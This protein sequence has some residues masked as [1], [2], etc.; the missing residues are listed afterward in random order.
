MSHLFLTHLQFNA[1]LAEELLPATTQTLSAVSLLSDVLLNQSTCL[2]FARQTLPNATPVQAESINQWADQIIES[3]FDA[4]PDRQPWRLHLWPGYGAE[5][6]GDYRCALIRAALVNRLKK[7]KRRL[8]RLLDDDCTPFTAETSLV[9]CILTAPDAGWLSVS[10]ASQPYELR[11]IVSAF[12]QGLVPLAD[13]RTAPSRAFTKLVETELHFG[14]QI[15]AGET[16]VDL[17]ASPG[18]WSHVALQ[19]G[20]QVTAIDRAKLREDL[21]RDPRLHFESTDAFKYK[22]PGIVDWLLCDVIAA[23]QRSIDLLL[24]WL[25][26]GHMR[27]FVVTIKFKG[28]NEYRLLDQLKQQAAPLCS[29]FGLKRLCANKNE[30]CAFG[31][32]SMII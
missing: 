4:L 17:G 25:R 7:R 20:A 21:M 28:D 31:T 6:G 27:H 29:E 19:R 16:C 30:V 23:P 9:Q 12:P 8:A 24:H 18:S 22:P 11:A 14:R 13:D 26:A 15:A 2:A 10:L 1:A 3:I 32:R 5:S